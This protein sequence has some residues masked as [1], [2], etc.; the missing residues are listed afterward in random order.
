MSNLPDTQLESW[1][2]IQQG[3]GLLVGR[4][5]AELCKHPE[6]L[7]LF[8]LR[9]I[10]GWEQSTISGRLNDL[11]D[12]GLAF[13]VGGIRVNPRSNRSQQVWVARAVQKIEVV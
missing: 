11:R 8:E 9:D 4:V 13:P 2:S 10:L 7:T 3:L 6:G 1:R 12:L 5:F